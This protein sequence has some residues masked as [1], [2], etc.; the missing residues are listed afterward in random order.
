MWVF[1]SLDWAGF[2][3]TWVVFG[4]GYI[5][6]GARFIELAGTGGEGGYGAVSDAGGGSTL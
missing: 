6:Q 2:R 5:R 1:S 3:R 4:D